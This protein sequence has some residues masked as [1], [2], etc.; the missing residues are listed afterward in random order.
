MEIQELINTYSHKIKIQIRFKDIDK[1]GHVNNANHLTYIESGRV[2][3]FND[4]VRTKIDWDK[5]GMILANC[6]I[7]YKQPILLEDNLFCYTK[8]SRFGT[9]SFDMENLLVIDNGGGPKLCASA[10]V[11]LVCMDY[12]AKQTIVVPKEWRDLVT[13]FEKSIS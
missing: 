10:K 13:A 8:V 7:A 9:K 1:L 2:D 6:E 3:Y 5:T 12:Q 4:V 11:T